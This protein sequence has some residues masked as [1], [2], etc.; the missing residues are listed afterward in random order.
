[1]FFIIFKKKMVATFLNAWMYI[2]STNLLPV[3]LLK[4]I[5]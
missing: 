1:M 3:S 4:V 2:C 5:L